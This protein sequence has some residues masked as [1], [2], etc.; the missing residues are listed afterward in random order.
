MDFYDN[1]MALMESKYL[2]GNAERS[3]IVR[4]HVTDHGEASHATR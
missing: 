4:H 3:C 1:Q 2:L